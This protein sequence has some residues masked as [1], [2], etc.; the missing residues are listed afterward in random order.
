MVVA[1]VG[2][3]LGKLIGALTSGRLAN[4]SSVRARAR[5]WYVYV[6]MRYSNINYRTRAEAR[7]EP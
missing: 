4:A 5:L 2:R 1:E 6:C 7:T 3:S